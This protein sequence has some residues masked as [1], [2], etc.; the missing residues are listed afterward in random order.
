[1]IMSDI[2]SGHRMASVST[3]LWKKNKSTYQMVYPC[4]PISHWYVKFGDLH[5]DSPPS[6]LQAW[7]CDV[8]VAFVNC[9]YII[10]LQTNLKIYIYTPIYRRLRLNSNHSHSLLTFRIKQLEKGQLDWMWKEKSRDKI[11]W[12]EVLGLD[13]CFILNLGPPLSQLFTVI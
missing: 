5:W 1:M 7:L 13:S 11:F 10:N 4:C 2:F 9:I 3:H 12:W 6:I 8:P